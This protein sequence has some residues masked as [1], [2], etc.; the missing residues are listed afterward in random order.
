[1]N[2]P[3]GYIKKK[4]KTIPFGYR[5]S[6]ST[7]GYLAPIPEQLELLNKYIVSVQEQHMS[8]R[9]A[10]EALSLE[11]NRKI[12]HVGLSL[13]VKKILLLLN[14]KYLKNNKEKLN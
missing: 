6:N 8:L 2:I 12:S 3:E 13:L 4:G 7:D 14:V 5:L 1:M 9:E 10:A 11:A